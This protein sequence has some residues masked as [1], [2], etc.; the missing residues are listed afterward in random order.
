[1]AE[2]LEAESEYVT[3]TRKITESISWTT[4]RPHNELKRKNIPQFRNSKVF[5]FDKKSIKLTSADAKFEVLVLLL[6][7]IIVD[8]EG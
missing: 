3:T 8:N 5:R 6:S 4:A 2:S 1:M 7:D